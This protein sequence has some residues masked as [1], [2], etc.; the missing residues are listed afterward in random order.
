MHPKSI[1]RELA[2]ETTIVLALPDFGRQRLSG[3]RRGWCLPDLERSN[4]GP[5]R[6][7]RRSPPVVK[8]AGFIHRDCP[9]QGKSRGSR[10]TSHISKNTA[11][12]AYMGAGGDARQD[13]FRARGSPQSCDYLARPWVRFAA[14][15]QLLRGEVAKATRF[16]SGCY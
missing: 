14:N 6:L 4:G 1:S 9:S 7:W 11:A 8:C 3:I 16:I 10:S 5:F 13:V 2:Q 12:T 15:G